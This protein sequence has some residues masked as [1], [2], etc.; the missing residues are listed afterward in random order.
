MKLTRAQFD[1]LIKESP[2]T[3]YDMMA[4]LSDQAEKLAQRLAELEKQLGKN[5]SNSSKPPSTDGFKK[6]KSQRGRGGKRGRP[7]GHKGETRPQTDTPDIVLEHRPEKCS[8]CNHTVNELEQER[9]EKR[10]VIE[11]KF[12]SE[13]TEHQRVSGKCPNCGEQLSGTFPEGVNAPVQFGKSVEAL[14][15]YL[16][17]YQHIPVDRSAELM[18]ML[19]NGNG[20]SVGTIMSKL[21]RLSQKA[22]PV[23]KIIAEEIL[24]SEVIHVDETGFGAEEKKWLHVL[25]TDKFTLYGAHA[26]RGFDAVHDIG[27]LTKYT[28]I[29]V[30]DF[31]S[32]YFRKELPGKHAMCND[33][34]LRELQGIIDT[35][36]SQTWAVE[37]QKFQRSSWKEVKAARESPLGAVSEERQDALDE[38]YWDILWTA[39][40]QIELL[41][42]PGAKRR[43]NA[44]ESDAERLF[45][46]FFEY[47]EAILRYISD[48]RVPFGNSQAERDIR[49][50]KVKMKVSGPFRT[51]I[52]A[53]IFAS[54]RSVISSARKHGFDAF[55]ALLSLS[56]GTFSFSPGT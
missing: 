38:Q 54:L 43:A 10:Q 50:M 6:T 15:A 49:M 47:G 53:D 26:K 52:G 35:E 1:E 42:K 30:H 46:R 27:I 40:K 9:I 13:T 32:T 2:G 18:N 17:S 8:H 21:S 51:D 25:S 19:M 12:S 36:P 41:R 3:V 16:T 34:L 31:W 37:M 5:S 20:P 23:V 7:K 29:M 11:V 55:S 33:H 48:P 44:A 45:S 14:A 39:Q 28:G 4:A 56:Y 22:E 24:H